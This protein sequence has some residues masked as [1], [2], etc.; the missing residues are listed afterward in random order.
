MKNKNSQSTASKNTL[1]NRMGLVL[2]SALI[3]MFFS[4]MFF[5]NEG[6]HFYATHFFTMQNLVGVLDFF[7]SFG[8]IYIISAL[9][10]LIPIHFFKV[11]TIWALFLASALLGWAIEGILPIMYHELPLSILWPAATWHVFVNVFLGWLLLRRVLEKNRKLL[12]VGVFVVMGLLWGLQGT[13]F[14]DTAGVDLSFPHGYPPEINQQIEEG[15]IAEDE[16]EKIYVPIKPV[17]FTWYTFIMTGMLFVGYL[18]VDRVGG[19]AYR[20]TKAGMY[21]ALIISLI[22]LAVLSQVFAL[23]FLLLVGG[24]VLVL[25]R[26]RKVETKPDIISTFKC[27]IKMSNLVLI[28]VMPLVASVT[29]PLYYNNNFGLGELFT[30]LIA[31]PMILASVVMFVVSI[32]KILKHKPDNSINGA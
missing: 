18:L 16:A 10:L 28:F 20:P 3:I 31:Y 29:Y 21:T 2:G 30:Y 7:I 5:L 14:W 19:N 4:E 24:V 9:W 1:F 17:D 23:L 8:L 6:D 32:G 27:N 12:T 11:R 13:W 15:V 26:N 25:N 22:L